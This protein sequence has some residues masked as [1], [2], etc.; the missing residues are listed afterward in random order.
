MTDLNI[1]ALLVV[2]KILKV[3]CD[4]I[5]QKDDLLLITMMIA[6]IMCIMIMVAELQQLMMMQLT[7][8]AYFVTYILLDNV[9]NVFY[10]DFVKELANTVVKCR[11]Q[12]HALI[13]ILESFRIEKLEFKV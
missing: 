10:A 6:L 1:V 3:S 5:Y 9:I 2:H 4:L 8:I 13:R 7:Y 12:F 11:F